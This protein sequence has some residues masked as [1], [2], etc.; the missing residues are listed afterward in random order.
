MPE[1]TIK[2]TSLHPEHTV[3]FY[4][5]MDGDTVLSEGKFQ[6][7]NT[8]FGENNI[9]TMTAGAVETP[10]HLRRGGN[11]RK[12]FDKAYSDAAESG[13]ISAVLHPFSFAY[14]QKFGYGKVSDHLIVRCPVRM[15]DFVD[16]CNDLSPYIGAQEQLEDLLT[17]YNQFTKGRHLMRQ[18]YDE[19][20]WKD[21][22]TY[23]YYENG[24]PTG[25]IS[26]TTEKTRVINHYE[27]GLMTVH[28]IVYTTPAALCAL[29]G[30]I[31]M[32]EGELDDVEFSHL[33]VCPEIELKLKHDTH[34]SYR[35]LP[36][37]MA[38]IINPEGLF[39]AQQYPKEE[40]AFSVRIT[41]D[42]LTGTGSFK[43]DY[44]G[45]ECVVKNLSDTAEVDLTLSMSAFSRLVYGY[46]GVSAKEAQYMN[47]VSINRNA[48]DF[49]RAFPSRPIGAFEHF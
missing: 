13:V 47:G 21:K 33:E 9:K 3:L 43:V 16:R 26:F 46:D 27:D 24:M 2:K 38:R 40:G 19:T 1:I 22:I 45:S 5:M 44:C 14:Y 29:L 28:E 31:R 42:F 30:F 25:Y 8:R 15:I 49:F 18:R 39:K 36:D 4:Y 10:V 35:R 23:I 7:I 17:V 41:D 48:D 11:V 37:L 32:Y 34:T 12:I 20:Y 6:Y